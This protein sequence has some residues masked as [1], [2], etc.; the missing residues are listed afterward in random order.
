MI[1]TNAVIPDDKNKKLVLVKNG[2]AVFTDVTT[3]YV[4]KNL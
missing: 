1:P 3:G 4:Q 2:K